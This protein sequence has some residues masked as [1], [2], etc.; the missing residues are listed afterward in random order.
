MLK[1]SLCLSLFFPLSADQ[2]YKGHINYI[3]LF[4]VFTFSFVD[5]LYCI[6]ILYFIIFAFYYFFF[7]FSGLD[8][9]VILQFLKGLLS[10]CFLPS[11]FLCKLI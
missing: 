10:N 4:E 6:F 8:L 5:S 2:Y 1:L 3:S 7:Y 11:F 9:M